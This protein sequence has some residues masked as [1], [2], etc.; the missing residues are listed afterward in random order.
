MD[1]KYIAGCLRNEPFHT[2]HTIRKLD[3]ITMIK[4]NV[5]KYVEN[6][7]D[8]T[9][10][11]FDAMEIDSID[12]Y[13]HVEFIDIFVE[14]EMMLKQLKQTLNGNPL[15]LTR[16]LLSSMKIPVPE[17][18]EQLSVIDAT[19]VIYEEKKNLQEEIKKIDDRI[20]G[21]FEVKL[22]TV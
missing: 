6:L 8:K 1:Q 16:A 20:M 9:K 22:A 21:V 12:P 17:E 7:N 2:K 15:I 18:K 13:I 19:K 4:F 11:I 10:D 3:D 5:D 14:T